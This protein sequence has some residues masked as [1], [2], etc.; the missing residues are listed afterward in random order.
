MQQTFLIKSSIFCLKNPQIL[1]YNPEVS[2][3][4]Q[5]TSSQNNTSRV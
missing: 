2:K 5:K 1:F 4:I 3:I